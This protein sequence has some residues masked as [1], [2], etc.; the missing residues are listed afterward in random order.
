VKVMPGELL[1]DQPARALAVYAH[2]DDVEVS[3]GG[4]L[5]RWSAAGA[6]VHVVVCTRGDKGSSDAGVDVEAL[7]AARRAETQA[8]ADTLGAR[9]L[10]L[11][12]YDDGAIE[13]DVVLRGRLVEV[14]RRV[15][16]EIVICPDPTAT[17]FGSTYVNHRDHRVVGWATVDA[18][19]PA[20]SSPLYY[21]AS[22]PPHA[23]GVLLLTGTLEPD[24]W[25]DV[26]GTVDTKAAAL[27]CHTSQVGG[28][29]DLVEEWV[30]QRAAAEGDRVGVAYAE[31]FRRILLGPG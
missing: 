1:R 24:V 20:A 22:G 9:S 19:A 15:E 26:S 30:R 10:D 8:A 29:E 5:A 28:R 7:A 21:P 2:P 25:V 4:T 27:R 17:F 11:L 6:T 13:N 31:G 12:G 16:P 23:V 18:C 14:V 3:C